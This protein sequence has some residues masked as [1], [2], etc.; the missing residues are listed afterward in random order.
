[1]IPMIPIRQKEQFGGRI[2]QNDKMIM[3]GIW[4]YYAN[5]YFRQ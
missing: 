1:M 4:A 2:R 5:I 3:V